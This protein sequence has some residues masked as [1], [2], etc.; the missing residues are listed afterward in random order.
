MEGS[1]SQRT[2]SSDSIRSSTE[3]RRRQLPAG[4]GGAGRQ[5][6]MQHTGTYCCGGV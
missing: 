4:H 6:P 5:R 1:I 2:P 3:T